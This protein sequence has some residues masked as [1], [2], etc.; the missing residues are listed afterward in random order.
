MNDF[1]DL[2]KITTLF[3]GFTAGIVA[4]DVY[5]FE[6]DKEETKALQV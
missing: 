5:H 2:D 4:I 6:E 1:L 3:W